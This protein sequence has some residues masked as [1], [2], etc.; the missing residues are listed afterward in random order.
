MTPFL[1]SCGAFGVGIMTY[2][3]NSPF[4]DVNAVTQ[5]GDTALHIAMHSQHHADVLHKLELL[6]PCISCIHRSNKNGE[7]P[8]TIA[9]ERIEDN[10]DFEQDVRLMEDTE[11]RMEESSLAFAMGLHPRIG[12]ESSMYGLDVEMAHMVKD[13]LRNY[14]KSRN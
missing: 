5:K 7:T 14:I 6:L 1:L 2:F 9:K 11:A 13:A 3:L 10:E 12:K 4:I 8:M